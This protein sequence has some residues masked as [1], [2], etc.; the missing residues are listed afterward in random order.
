MLRV[1]VV[2][3]EKRALD[4]FERVVEE[5]KRVTLV[6]KFMNAWEAIDFVRSASVDVA[7]LDIEMPFINGLELAQL[8]IKERPALE[9]IMVTAYSQYAL[10]ALQAHAAG[11]LLKPIVIDDIQEQID[12]ILR[13]RQNH[14][15][16]M[17]EQLL[18]V[19]CF[20]PF[21]CHRIGEK[22]EPI[23]FRTAKAEE[24]FALLLHY[25]GKPV[26]KGTLIE[27]LWP[28]VE[29]GKSDN[30]FHVT[31]TYI[32]NALSEKGL[33]EILIRERDNY[34]LN[35]SKLQC[36]LLKFEA[37]YYEYPETASDLYT[38]LY[39][40]DKLYDWAE[41]TRQWFENQF[42]R[43]QYRLADQYESER[44]DKKAM[45]AISK[46][47]LKNPYEE[48][49]VERLIKLR[50]KAGDIA[51]ASQL[52]KEYSKRLEKELGIGPA[53]GLR[54]LIALGNVKKT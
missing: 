36:D 46:I 29:Q 54:K 40:E 19:H 27:A 38:G 49:A 5:E 32:R 28:E 4:R 16:K 18:E 6:G 17:K 23:L 7:F 52:Y 44:N 20:G 33:K 39:Y 41:N 51:I 14:P 37:S 10:K 48:E 2:D 11:Y 31:C 21:H 22:S 30:H 9:V 34:R 50:V 25:Q 47:L 8:L 12:Y 24:L 45:E 1:I 35:M 3:D 42:T 13:K 53:E 26:S 15:G 43:L